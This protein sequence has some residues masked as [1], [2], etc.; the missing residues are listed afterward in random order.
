MSAVAIKLRV[1]CHG[2]VVQESSS[3]TGPLWT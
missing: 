1:T 2:H 3:K